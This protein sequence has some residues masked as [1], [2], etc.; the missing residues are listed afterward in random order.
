MPHIMR[1]ASDRP[2][3]AL[4]SPTGLRCNQQHGTTWGD[5]HTSLRLAIL[6]LRP[7]TCYRVAPLRAG[8][9]G[10]HGLPGASAGAVCMVPR[11]MVPRCMVPRCMV[12]W[13]TNS[14]RARLICSSLCKGA[15]P[16]NPTHVLV[17]CNKFALR[18]GS[19][20][21]YRWVRPATSLLLVDA[22]TPL[23]TL[24]QFVSWQN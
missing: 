4:L 9:G 19:A 7:T 1:Q 3:C 18:G 5:P 20:R 6:V 24:K 8:C 23:A 14:R 2:Q 21:G 13:C 16:N 17:A 11:C 12:P 15:S 22:V 10:R